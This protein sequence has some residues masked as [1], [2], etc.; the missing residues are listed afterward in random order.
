MRGGR[1]SLGAAPHPGE[2]AELRVYIDVPGLNRAASQERFWPSCMG[3]CKGPPHSY[4]RLPFGMPSVATAYQRNLRSILVAQEA[5]H[6][7]VLTKME[8]V[9]GEPPGPREPPE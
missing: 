7:V 3:R 4:V 1:R 2:D 5:R 6:H 9:L 8:T